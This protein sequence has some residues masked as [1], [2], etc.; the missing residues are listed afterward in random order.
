[1]KNFGMDLKRALDSHGTG[2]SELA[3]TAGVTPNAVARGLKRIPFQRK[4]N[5]SQNQLFARGF[6]VCYRLATVVYTRSCSKFKPRAPRMKQRP[7]PLVPVFFRLVPGVNRP[8]AEELAVLRSPFDRV[9]LSGFALLPRWTAP[10]TVT[11]QTAPAPRADFVRSG[12]CFIVHCFSPDTV[13]LMTR[14]GVPRKNSLPC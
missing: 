14:Q 9:G 2:A 3:K 8:V 6:F 5:P 13:I 1:M 4:K 10:A 11:S 7:Q 12:D